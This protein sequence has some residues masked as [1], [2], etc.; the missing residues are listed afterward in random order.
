MRQWGAFVLALAGAVILAVIATTPPR[1]VAS[2]APANA[3]SAKRAMED[4]A[5]I[6][7]APRPTGS[8]EN[9][10]VRAYLVDRLRGLGLTARTAT[11]VL[12]PIAVGRLDAWRG[13]PAAPPPVTNVVGELRGTDRSLPAVLLMAH[14]DSVWGSPGAA[15]DA[16]GVGSILEVVRAIRAS[17]PARRDLIVL[18]SDAEELG[19][20]GAKTFFASDPLRGR[21]GVIVDLETRGGGGRTSMFETSADNGGLIDLFGS[22]VRRP[23][24]TSLS[25]FVYNR[26]P[27]STDYTVA[28]KLGVPGYNF[29]F[30]GRPGLYHSP[31][32]TAAALDQGSIQ[33]M[34]R[35]A[36]DLS[37]GLLAAPALPG[38]AP[39][40]VFF[41][42]FGLIF[43]SYAAWVGWVLLALAVG[44]YGAAGW[45]RTTGAEVGRG[46]GVTVALIVAAAVLLYVLNLVSGAAGPVNYYD[47]LAAIPRLQGQALLGS[48]AA[49]ALAWGLLMDGRPA[50]GYAPG[51]ALPL[52]LLGAIVQAVAPTAVFPI[53]IPLLLGGIA[54]AAGRWSGTAGTI[55]AVVAAMV[56][57][58]FLMTLAY[59]LM[60]GVGPNIP[61]VVALP[62]A[63][64]ALLAMP[65]TPVA[66]R[67]TAFLVAAISS[68]IAL[69]L[70]LWVRLDAVA[71]SVPVYSSFK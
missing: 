21:V 28:K 13:M 17:G 23:V 45:R 40:R 41:D 59:G 18:F 64:A 33:D 25:I 31:L 29:A 35:Q 10:R 55:A 26:L 44:G 52:L 66:R 8:A 60:Q 7:R 14:H 46:A 57:I 38:K 67:R 50:T 48:L 63:L 11:G 2:D 27:N 68:A 51:A 65:L 61:S 20:E 6:S 70:A 69:A 1:P 24:A 22:V 42:A 16:A 9:A 12:S 71:P 47:R 5:A 58:G 36:L 62:L 39:D 30:I 15:D 32:A 19:L 3:F 54:A 53:T 49:V 56:G 43:V 34:G 4:I 37:R